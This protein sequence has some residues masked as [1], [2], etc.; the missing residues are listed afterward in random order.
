MNGLIICAKCL[1]CCFQ[2]AVKPPEVAEWSEHKNADGRCYYYNA[3][4]ME[5][6][7]E[8]PK[9]IVDWEGMYG[10]GHFSITSTHT[11]MCAPHRRTH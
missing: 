2:P 6:T 1:Q 10:S 9:V 11:H 5:S 8:K 7:W 3:R 4:S